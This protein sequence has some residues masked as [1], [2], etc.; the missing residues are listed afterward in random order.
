MKLTEKEILANWEEFRKRINLFG[1]RAKALNGMY[2][3]I[4]ERVV[5]MPASS[6]DHHHN[7]MPGG[8]VDHVLR[9]MDCSEKLHDVWQS[10]GTDVS[11]F[12]KEE[13][14]FAAMHHD[15]GKVGFPGEGNEA[16]IPNES[17]W[18]RKNQGKIY[19]HNPKNPFGLVP[20]ISIWWLQEHGVK[21]SWNEFQA[22]R[23]HDGL[24]DEANRAYFVS[25][26]PD[27]KLRTPMAIIL[28]HADHMAA[29]IEYDKWAST[30]TDVK[31]SS[32][33]N[34]SYGKKAQ[35]KKLAD[36]AT[37]SNESSSD[38]QQVFNDL[39]G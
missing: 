17:E 28:H 5:M 32:N 11:G 30:H 25:R 14:L 37:S 9:V 27:S 1:S 21:M 29:R 22:I 16:Y 2:D 8:Y 13:L 31:P 18:H 15:L 4:E 6:V 39:F 23:I 10:M 24:Y 3:E 7:A 20:D 34:M 36:V 35:A 19:A 38:L 26:S 12:T 33:V